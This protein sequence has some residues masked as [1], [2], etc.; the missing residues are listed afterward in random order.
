LAFDAF[1]HLLCREIAGMTAAVGGLDLLVMTG[2]IGEHAALVRTEV[3]RRLAYLGVSIDPT[4]SDGA[5]ADADIS[6]AGAGVR[7]LVVTAREDLEIVRQV[8][9]LPTANPTRPPCLRRVHDRP[10]GRRARGR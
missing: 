7:T 3:G 6:A 8:V 4:A 9:D 10:A 5:T 2:G 1:V